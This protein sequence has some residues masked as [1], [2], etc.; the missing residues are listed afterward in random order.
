MKSQSTSLRFIL[1]RFLLLSLS[2]FVFSDL[3][4]QERR[5]PLQEKTSSA[6]FKAGNFI[7]INTSEYSQSA[8]NMTD[9]IKKVL[10]S[11]GSTCAE[12]DVKNVHVYPNVSTAN[13]NRSWGYFNNGTTGFPFKEGIIL[14]TGFARKAG[15]TLVS[16]SLDDILGTGTDVDLENAI[17]PEQP[18]FD[19]TYIEFDFVPSNSQITFNYLFASEE[20][21][22]YYPCGGFSDGFAL[23]LKKQGDAN[24]TNLAVLPN[25]TPVSVTNIVPADYS[26]GPINAEYFGGHN[27]MNTETNFNG[28]VVPLRAQANVIPGQTYHFKMVLA[29]A[30]DEYFDSAVF[31]EA[32]SF[33]IGVNIQD[34]NGQTLASAIKMCNNEPQ[35]L[36]ATTAI[37]NPLVK[38]YK[39][40]VLIPGANSNTY[41]AVTPGVY[42]VEIFDG[43][44]SSCAI[45]SK[46]IDI[47]AG[48]IPAAG[49][50]VL[51][52]CGDSG[53][54]FFNLRNA[55]N[56]I[57]SQTGATFKYYEL[58]ADA[59]LGNT[60][61]IPTT[62]DYN[63]YLSPS[64]TIYVRVGNGQC[65]KVVEL[66]LNIVS[67]PT[68][69]TITA[70]KT[71]LCDG[72]NI[73]LTS[74]A[75]TGNVWSTG[76]TTKSITVTQ[77]GTYSV[78]VNL[79]SCDSG[80][81]SI[82][83]TKQP[84]INVAIAGDLTLCE[85]GTIVIT[86]N[87]PTGNIW[88]TGETSQ[89]ITVSNSGVYSLSV[90]TSNG[91]TFT[92]SA[93]V[94]DVPFISLK[95]EQPQVITCNLS[96]ISLDAAASNFQT[97][98]VVLW[99]AS[100][101][102]N[103]LSG[104]NTLTPVVNAAGQYTLTLKRGKCSKTISVQVTENKTPVP[105][106][107]T[108]D[109]LT[110]CEGES[111]TLTAQGG[112]SYIWSQLPGS[113]STQI[114]SPKSTTV[115]SVSGIGSNGCVSQPVLITITVV[116]KI[117]SDVQGG[118]ICVNDQIILDAGAG[119]N[120][121]YT[122]N[123][124]EKTQTI[125][126]K[127]IGEYSVTIDNGVCSET[128]TV[129]VEAAKLPVI[130]QVIYQENSLT[131]IAS[132]PGSGTLEYSIDGGSSWQDSKLFLNV[133]KNKSHQIA[134][135]VKT[136]SCI[137]ETEYF[138]FNLS[139]VITPNADGYND[140]IDFSGISSY[141]NF[142]ARIFDRYSTE[143]F[144]ADTTL[145]S[146]DGTAKSRKLSSGTYWY[147]VI[148]DD[149]VTAITQKRQGWIYL[150]M[151]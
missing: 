46:E 87:F 94:T 78:K 86:S 67:A 48:V 29:D 105:I 103:I 73:V 71:I 107:L 128:F 27:T 138:S 68:A 37:L 112:V 124:G 100:N 47:Q 83:I 34:Q 26:C 126:A 65:F 18:L 22:S 136:T 104:A 82:M 5:K 2:V 88:S 110:I 111:A 145:K 137:A 75:N 60:N 38:W 102:G 11:G 130:T 25:N 106:V 113:A 23:L 129:K 16:S 108:A 33:N 8:Y 51:E 59:E 99:N 127:K 84:D 147:I 24:Y 134:V 148:W 1:T 125:T 143:V 146:W 151:Y 142:S 31:L 72:G 92:K 35:T 7:N 70:S 41:V 57:F 79:G 90:T 133:T 101:G 109:R 15:N 49:N 43:S 40:N 95:I 123:T 21:S 45:G 149:P 4:S 139:N 115:Y 122:W 12:P 20:Y 9:L 55:Q 30:G 93:T 81:S 118:A 42:K 80:S 69:P 77:A 14:S 6:S 116:P 36:I 17:S 53:T 98:D 50:A 74:S 150:K 76:Q 114:V 140:K 39:N 66:K 32:G 119:P 144:K 121:S 97:G 63:S 120:Y 117:V 89:S 13:Q 3:Y 19:A 56:D 28:R 131:V 132:N 91:C 62:N 85:N 44:T 10:I 58:K 52:G 141:P 135:R 61:V 96:Q 54:A 64:K